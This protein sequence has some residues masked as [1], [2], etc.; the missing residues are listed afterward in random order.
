ME[1]S[2]KHLST[3]Q[4]NALVNFLLDMG[5]SIPEFTIEE[6]VAKLNDLP[7]FKDQERDVSIPMAQ[8]ILREL[9]TLPKPRRTTTPSDSMAVAREAKAK[10]SAPTITPEDTERLIKA[11]ENLTAAV[12]LVAEA[13]TTE[14]GN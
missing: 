7:A 3:I 4:K 13:L 11:T 6:I 14:P 12:L 1:Q 8:R 2:R 10:K 9:P 5:S